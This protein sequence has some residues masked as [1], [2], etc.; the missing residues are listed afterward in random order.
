MNEAAELLGVSIKTLQRWDQT[1]KIGLVRTPNGRRRL[2]E[3]E[4]RKIVGQRAIQGTPR[5]LAIYGRVS[6]HDQKKKGD[7]KRQI[8]IIKEKMDLTRFD[9]TIVIEDVGSG[10]NDRRKGL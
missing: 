1:G 5:V 10:L 8:D 6:S 3:R 9:D 4:L 2:P 7:L